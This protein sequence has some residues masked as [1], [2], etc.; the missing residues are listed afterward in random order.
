[1]DTYVILRRGGWRTADDLAEAAAR[2]TA[3]GERMPDDVLLVE[4][5]EGDPLDAADRPDRHRC[6]ALPVGPWRQLLDKVARQDDLAEKGFAHRAC[7]PQ[8]PGKQGLL[9]PRLDA[10]ERLRLAQRNARLNSHEAGHQRAST[11][12]MIDRL[13][14]RPDAI[15]TRLVSR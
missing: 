15:V 5:D 11:R 14:C 2:S 9:P 3:E 4:M 1:M 8:Q 7:G 10:H 6:Q 12:S 13:S